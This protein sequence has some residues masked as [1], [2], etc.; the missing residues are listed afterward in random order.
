MDMTLHDESVE[1]NRIYSMICGCSMG[2]CLVSKPG[3][4]SQFLFGL[5]LLEAFL[6][7]GQYT[8]LGA[9]YERSPVWT[10]HILSGNL[11]VIP[12]THLCLSLALRI[13]FPHTLFPRLDVKVLPGLSFRSIPF[14]KMIDRISVV[15]R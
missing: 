4:F 11:L 2:R 7:R 12:T 14:F 9:R 1:Y 13:L 3:L 6:R 8:F 10:H 15:G 5:L